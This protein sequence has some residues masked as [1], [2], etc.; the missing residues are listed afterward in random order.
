MSDGAGEVAETG[1]GVVGLRPG[2]RV[3]PHFLPDWTAGALPPIATRRMRGV[4]MAGSLSEYAVVPATGLVPVP[5]HLSFEEA[6]TIPIA[7]TTAWNAIRAGDIHPGSTVLLLGTGGV[8]LYA[9][10]FAK[11]SGARVIITSSSDEKLERARALGADMTI[12]YRATPDWDAKVLELTG[13][14][15]V[16][17]VVETGGGETFARSLNAAANEATVFVVGFLTGADLSFSV[18]PVMQKTLRIVGSNT[19]SVAD[20]RAAA[21]AIAANRIKPALD[22]VYSFEDAPDA[23]ATMSRGGHF[24]KLAVSI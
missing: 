18:F 12:N 7:A 16:D 6:A 9:L 2:E 1:A 8:S 14:A 23:Y 3:I 5:E 11:A 17:L 19:G 10:Q 4:N 21:L 22:R 15:G 20:L 24:G 13:G